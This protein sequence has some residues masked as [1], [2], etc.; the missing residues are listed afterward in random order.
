MMKRTLFIVIPICMAL[1]ATGIF[2]YRTFFIQPIA[3]LASPSSYVLQDKNWQIHFNQKMDPASFTKDNLFVKNEQGEKIDISLKWNHDYTT[4][5]IV[6]PKNGYELNTNY[7]IEITEDVQT[8]AGKT[9]ARAFSHTFQAGESLQKIKDKAQLMTLLKER[10]NQTGENELFSMEMEDSKAVNESAGEEAAVSS[11]NVQVAG[12]DEGDRI[13]TDGEYIYFSRE[14]DIVIASASN[15]QQVTTISEKNFTPEEIYLH[16]N[17]LISIGYKHEPMREVIQEE[18]EASSSEAKR[19]IAIY[20]TYSSQTTIY[21]YDLSHASKPKRI[22]EVSLE[23]TISASR[24]MDDQLYIIANE[25][26]P[27]HIMENET[28]D[29]RPFIKDSAKGEDSGPLDFE[30]MYF[31]PDSKDG[32]FMVIAAINLSNLTKEAVIESYLGSS[33]HIYMSK[34]HLYTTVIKYEQPKAAASSNEKAVLPSTVS[35]TEIVQFKIQKQ[36]VQYNASTT[37]PGSLINSFSMDERNKTFR[38]A[39]TE[40][41]IGAGEKPSTNNMYTFDLQLQPLGSI[42]GLAKG[43]RIYSVRFMENVAYM[44][45]FKQV[46]PLF[47]ID[48]KNPK[49]PT[50]LGELKIPGFSDYLHPLGKQHLIGFGQQTKLVKEGNGDPQVRIDGLKI[51]L[52]DITNPAKPVEQSNEILGQ[53]HSYSEINTDH[54][55]LFKHPTKD[56]FGIPATLFETKRV[57][58]GEAV[59]EEQQF[60][61]Q[62]LFLY[63]IS[64]T[65][66]IVLKGSISHQ[67]KNISHERWESQIQRAVSIG[68][69]LYT[70]SMDGMQIYNLKKE[71]TTAKVT[72][73]EQSGF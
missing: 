56:L 39:T 42:K 16:D 73:P 61:Y 1:I 40:N 48:L 47:V 41:E 43:E 28:I 71:K 60:L 29:P 35:N 25:R 50:V 32:N 44:V 26:P 4:V 34:K 69:M 65:K 14:R 57:Q 68:D 54:N 70:F 55:A 37:V 20:P 38:V 22:R 67:P 9:L 24:K 23:G 15:E 46:D 18:K 10:M 51:S 36:G 66:G 13:K 11:T 64:P 6:A 53:G 2:L 49:K 17:L 3:E 21:L 31:F 59:Y 27:F 19:D 8:T 63:E 72:F 5:T 12:I 7:S 52:F 45:T 62:G 33:D 58:K 30:N